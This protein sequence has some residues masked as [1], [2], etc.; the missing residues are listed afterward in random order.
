MDEKNDRMDQSALSQFLTLVRICISYPPAADLAARELTDHLTDRVDSLTAQGVSLEEAQ[1]R[2][3][4]AMGDPME[5]GHSFD[6]LYP[7]FWHRLS[8]I[9]L[10]AAVLLLSAALLWNCFLADSGL[11]LHSL[12]PLKTTVILDHAMFPDETADP[13]LLHPIQAYGGGT[14]GRAAL[15][16]GR[17]DGTAGVYRL[18][19]GTVQLRFSVQLEHAP[20]FYVAAFDCRLTDDL[21]NEYDPSVYIGAAGAAR[22]NRL[23]FANDI[24]PAARSFTFTASSEYTQEQVSLYLRTGEVQP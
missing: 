19:T 17:D 3:V 7:A 22:Q 4:A 6:R 23:I 2:A 9:L 12:L 13:E 15:S 20:W 18:S 5:I 11:R 1:R 24:D 16:P 14:L 10:V 21:G 8:H